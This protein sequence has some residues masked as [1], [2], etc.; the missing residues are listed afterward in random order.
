MALAALL[1]LPPSVLGAGPGRAEEAAAAQS[2]TELVSVPLLRG[3]QEGISRGPGV[4]DDG[5]VAVFESFSSFLVR[6]DTNEVS[7]VFVRWLDR[8]RTARISVSAEAVQ[9]DGASFEAVISGDGRTVAFRSAAANLVLGDSNG[10]D[11]VFVAT[12]SKDGAERINVST[13]A[14]QA[15]AWSG[16]AAISASGRFVAFAS[17]ADNLVDDDVN[18]SRDVFVRDRQQRSTELI[19][20]SGQGGGATGDSTQPALS[21]DGRFVAFVSQ[22]EDLVADDTNGAWDVFVRDRSTDVTQRVSLAS[23]GRASSSD[24][25]DPA[26]SADGRF[27][28]FTSGAGEFDQRCRTFASSVFV[29]DRDHDRT[30]CA[31]ARPLGEKGTSGATR[32]VVVQASTPAMSADGRF[33]VMYTTA[34]L[35][36]HHLPT[37][38]AVPI[39]LGREPIGYA[40]IRTEPALD[41]AGRRLIFVEDPPPGGPKGRRRRRTVKILDRGDP[42]LTVCG[43][44]LTDP[45]E[46]CDDGAVSAPGLA[47]RADCTLVACGDIDGDGKVATAK[48][49]D[50][51][52][53]AA[54]RGIE[55]DPRVCDI[56]NSGGRA[57]ITDGMLLLRM[58]LDGKGSVRCP[59]ASD[60]PKPSVATP[61]TTD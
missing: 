48:D 6:G 23:N 17:D 9:G 11:D 16:M 32:R 25:M 59:L 4:S 55:C 58:S 34:G 26:I 3:R 13:Q 27:V 24:S 61:A 12:L 29:R 47:C 43:N 33:V 52:I 53:H 22:S 31:S 14:E 19:S 44:F 36:L 7:D 39:G 2:A 45:G 21:A 37:R 41:A 42:A 40:L 35:L 49:A 38:R 18:G 20:I 10:V 60:T 56:D 54:V 46:E 50:L 28:V 15:N 51:L 57:G 5:R 1:C 8:G 30:W